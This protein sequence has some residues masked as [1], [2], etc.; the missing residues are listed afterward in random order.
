[1]APHQ[2]SR[3][4]KLLASATLVMAAVLLPGCNAA[5]ERAAPVA[6]SPTP[7]GVGGAA[8]PRSGSFAGVLT[9]TR[10][11]AS[12]EGA[13]SIAGVIDGTR[14]MLRAARGVRL[15]AALD[16]EG[17]FAVEGVLRQHQLGTKLQI[18]TGRIADGVVTIEARFVVPGRPQTECVATGR[19]PVGNVLAPTAR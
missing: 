1:M 13:P 8:A 18:Y 4:F 12:E 9:Y 11:C 17:R 5:T 10:P 15:T 6:V 14:L 2:R 16:A 19:M 7:A 3:E